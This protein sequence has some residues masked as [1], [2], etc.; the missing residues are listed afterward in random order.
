MKAQ[1]VEGMAYSV[2]AL[3]SVSMDLV[4]I[5]LELNRR[6]GNFSN[7]RISPFSLLV[8]SLHFLLL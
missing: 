2:V 6:E 1:S 8:N 5:Y 3:H 7:L 4:L